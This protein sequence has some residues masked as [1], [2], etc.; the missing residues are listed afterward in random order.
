LLLALLAAGGVYLLGSLGGGGVIGGSTQTVVVAKN[1]IPMR[2][3]ITKDDLDILKGVST[4]VTNVYSNPSDLLG[5]IAEIQISKGGIITRDMLAKDIGLVPA[6]A[7]PAYLPLAKG[8]VAM[9]IPTGEQQGVAGH[10]TNGDYIT[11]IASASLTTFATGKAQPTGPTKVV[12][13]TVF[14]N[15]RVIGLGPATSNLQ[16]AGGTATVGGTTP[17]NGGLTSSLTIEVTQCDAEFFTW[18]LNNTQL[19]YTLESV[20]DY[21]STPPTGPDTQNCPNGFDSAKGVSQ[22]AVEARYHFTSL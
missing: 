5:L 19:K 9:T 8:Y 17:S 18:F 1:P 3:Q 6:G 4:N 15:I 12:S 16:P 13:K 22:A 7:G 14:T 10:I 11:V 21:Q 2:H 20:N